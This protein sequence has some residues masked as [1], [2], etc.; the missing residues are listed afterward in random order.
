MSAD[1]PLEYESC[2]L[3]VVAERW[4][5]LA[6]PLY[7]AVALSPGSDPSAARSE[8]PA[9]SVAVEGRESGAPS[10]SSHSGSVDRDLPSGL[11]W[12][13]RLLELSGFAGMRTACLLIKSKRYMHVEASSSCKSEAF[14]ALRA[15]SC[16]Q[17]E[18]P[19]RTKVL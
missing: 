2:S 5:V 12:E 8:R 17:K 4:L 10:T 6:A 7:S 19:S 18:F 15:S 13:S 16:S 1:S 11:Y 14:A 3:S 9:S